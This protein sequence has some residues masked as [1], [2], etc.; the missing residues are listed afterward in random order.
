MKLT[1]EQVRHVANLARLKLS[2]DEEARFTA[3]LSAI[4]EA[5][6]TLAEVDTT[7]VPPTSWVANV[8]PL[9]R[10]DV[11][12]GQLS[13]EQAL[14]NAPQAVGSSFAIPRVIE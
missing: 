10:A 13:S 2:A 9:D 6:E 1:L 4:L 8:A 7:Q 11:A 14:E 12:A 5:V 3:R